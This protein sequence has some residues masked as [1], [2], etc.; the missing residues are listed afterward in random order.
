MV[1]FTLYISNLWVKD[2]K[3]HLRRVDSLLISWE[4]DLSKEEILI[5]SQRWLNEKDL[6]TNQ[7]IGLKKVGESSLE[8]EPVGVIEEE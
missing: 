7:M 4:S 2:E 1:R 6:L 8:I 5:V 3:L